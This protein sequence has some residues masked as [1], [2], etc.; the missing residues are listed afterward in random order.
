MIATTEQLYE[1]AKRV[2][3]GSLTPEVLGDGSPFILACSSC[4][5]AFPNGAEMGMVGQHAGIAHEWDGE[6]RLRLDL[7]WIGEGPPPEP[8]S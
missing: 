7:V 4:G 6:S 1:Q 3:R 8:R 5:L 2:L